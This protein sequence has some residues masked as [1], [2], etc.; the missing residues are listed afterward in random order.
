MPNGDKNTSRHSCDTDKA[1]RASAIGVL[2]THVLNTGSTT[3]LVCSV[4]IIIAG[5]ITSVVVAG[6]L[7]VNTPTLSVHTLTMCSMSRGSS[8]RCY[9]E[10][11]LH[12]R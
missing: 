8:R 10:P 4:A 12:G 11:G 5:G 6:A 9:D 3:T 7:N 2:I 1:G